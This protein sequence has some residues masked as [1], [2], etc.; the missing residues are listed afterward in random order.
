[1]QH[2]NPNTPV[3][4]VALI[5]NAREMLFV[6]LDDPVAAA[7]GMKVTRRLS[8]APDTLEV[9]LVAPKSSSTFQRSDNSW[10]SNI[11]Y[12]HRFNSIC[13]TIVT[14]CSAIFSLVMIESFLSEIKFSMNLFPARFSYRWSSRPP[15][16]Y[17]SAGSWLILRVPCPITLPVVQWD[18]PVARRVSEHPH[19][20]WREY[21]PLAVRSASETSHTRHSYAPNNNF[22]SKS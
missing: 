12:E 18:D 4:P 10:S 20:S 7:D 3:E 13:L 19:R 11:K 2:F 5:N 17:K 8:R 6:K 1:M 21:F 15:F 22:H 14:F 16:P 9:D